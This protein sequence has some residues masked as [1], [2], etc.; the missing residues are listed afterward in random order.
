MATKIQKEYDKDFYS[1]ILHNVSLLRAGKFAEIDTPHLLEELES[2]GK[3]EK[4]ELI[5]RLAVLIA[6]LLKWKFQPGK[7]SKSWKYTIKEQ[8]VSLIDLLEE[9]PSLRHELEIKIEHVYE[10]AVFSAIRETGLDERDFPK[11]CP[12]SLDQCLDSE[13]FPDGEIT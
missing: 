11:T 9:S 10:Q 12:F 6:H 4:R 3:S 2:M 1:W 7:R 13:F 5:S 8:R